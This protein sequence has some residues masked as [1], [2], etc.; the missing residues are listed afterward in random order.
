LTAHPAADC[1]DACLPAGRAGRD[2]QID[3]LTYELYSLTEEKIKIV[4][5]SA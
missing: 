3:K 4:E 2:N 1:G 5:E